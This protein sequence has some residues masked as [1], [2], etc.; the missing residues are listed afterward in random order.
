MEFRHRCR[1]DATPNPATSSHTGDSQR[2]EQLRGSGW[3]VAPVVSHRLH[4]PGG[5][6]QGV[7]NDE[8][9]VVQ[10]TN[11]EQVL[12]TLPGGSGKVG[13][14]QGRPGDGERGGYPRGAVRVVRRTRRG[15]GHA[16]PSPARPRSR[17]P[18]QAGPGHR[19]WRCGG[20]FTACPDRREHHAGAALDQLRHRRGWPRLDLQRGVPPHGGHQLRQPGQ[21]GL[22][23]AR[24][25]QL[26]RGHVPAKPV[27]KRRLG[28][29]RHH[30]TKPRHNPA[31]Q[32]LLRAGQRPVLADLG[33]HRGQAADPG[34]HRVTVGT[35]PGQAHRR[36]PPPA[37]R[38]RR[39]PGSG[40][41][42]RTRPPHPVPGR[43]RLPS[44]QAT[45]P[46]DL[47]CVGDHG[48]PVAW[49]PAAL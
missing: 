37:A 34:I 18:R 33:Q 40:P 44:H 6:R 10:R 28:P 45:G 14:A 20:V 3:P 13:A 46:S 2:R 38:G 25:E 8:S 21:C 39:L 15:P 32:G 19:S 48:L 42:P 12:G 31:G 16:S 22:L 7:R 24:G 4:V 47:G 41:A 17:P 11:G 30:G 36:P 27:I 29:G 35:R 23:A 9:A 1:S 26:Q 43:P 49:V 5:V